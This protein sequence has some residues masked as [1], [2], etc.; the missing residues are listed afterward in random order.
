MSKTAMLTPVSEIDALVVAFM[1]EELSPV[2]PVTVT[3]DMLASVWPVS[4]VKP[5]PLGNSRKIRWAL[6][7]IIEIAEP[8][9]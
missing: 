6:S 9:I 3:L 8:D 2:A 7:P 1:P 5:F 4:I